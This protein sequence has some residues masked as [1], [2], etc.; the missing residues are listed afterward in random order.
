MSFRSIISSIFCSKSGLS[1]ENF[2]ANSI[3]PDPHSSS[4]HTFSCAAKNLMCSSL[5][6]AG[7]LPREDQLRE[8][9]GGTF[10]SLERAVDGYVVTS[11]IGGAEAIG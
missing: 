4:T 2:R 8:L 3:S 5:I 6:M 10:R 1:S 11:V 9:L 7:W